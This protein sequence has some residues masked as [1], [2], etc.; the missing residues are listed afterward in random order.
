MYTAKGVVKNIEYCKKETD[1]PYLKV[2]VLID[3]EEVPFSFSVWEE[4]KAFE[5]FLPP[6]KRYL[7]EIILN[8]FIVKNDLIFAC[9][10]F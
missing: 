10:N 6:C 1:E 2:L 3:G 7:L 9:V 4:K 8:H 5:Q